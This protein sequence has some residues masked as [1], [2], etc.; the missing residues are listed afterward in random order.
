V[1]SELLDF[2]PNMRALAN[3]RQRA[4]VCAL[5]EAPSKDGR[6]IFA[7]RAAGYGTENS[8]NKSLSVIGSRLNVSDSIQ[9]AIAEKSQRR[10][11]GLSPSAVKALENLIDDPK[12]RDH[13]RGI[14]MILDRSDPV[15]TTHHVK[16]EHSQ[17]PTVEATEKVLK[18]IDELARRAGLLAPPPQMIDGEFSLVADGAGS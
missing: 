10:L 15:E 18:R 13:V 16:V 9:A 3:D 11:R 2:G 7:A 12:H 5:F 4:F 17:P 8:N 14:A 6:I 1:E